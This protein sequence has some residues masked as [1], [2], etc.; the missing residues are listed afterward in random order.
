MDVDPLMT[1]YTNHLPPLTPDFSRS[2]RTI[3]SSYWL[4]IS[5][6]K[7]ALALFANF[8]AGGLYVS[9][10]VRGPPSIRY[11][12]DWRKMKEHAEKPE[13]NQIIRRAQLNNAEYA[14]P[15]ISVL[16]YLHS[17][18][19]GEEATMANGLIVAGSLI[20]LWGQILVG[21]MLQTAGAIPRYA[22]MALLVPILQAVTA[23]DVGQFSAGNLAR[24]TPVQAANY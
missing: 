6:G 23:K 11:F 16:L 19:V 13:A 24:F 10:F 18:G 22:G 4:E 7:A 17:Q 15:L 3:V 21:P 9:T 8:L 5:C 12:G 1:Y 14:G 2:P 20:H